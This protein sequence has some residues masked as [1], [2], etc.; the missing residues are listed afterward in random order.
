MKS[1]GCQPQLVGRVR[2][3]FL[4]QEVVKSTPVNLTLASDPVKLTS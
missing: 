2:P 4:T 3:V 1:C